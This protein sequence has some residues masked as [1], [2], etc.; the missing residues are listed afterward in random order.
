MIDLNPINLLM[1]KIAIKQPAPLPQPPKTCRGRKT[2]CQ[3]LMRT[4]ENFQAHP[5]ISSIPMNADP[6]NTINISQKSTEEG[7]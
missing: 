3:I 2:V 5:R 1:T 4:T 7:V 6:E